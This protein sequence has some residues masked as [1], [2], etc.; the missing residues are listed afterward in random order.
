VKVPRAL[1]EKWE[2]RLRAEGLGVLHD[3]VIRGRVVV[4]TLVIS[5]Y[6]QLQYL[7]DPARLAQALD[8][9]ADGDA[10]RFDDKGHRMLAATQGCRP[11][12]VGDLRRW[13]K[14]RARILAK[15]CWSLAEGESVAEC[16]RRH[17]CSEDLAY[18]YLRPLFAALSDRSAQV[19]DD[20]ANRDSGD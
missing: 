19:D 10:S 16:A 13:P 7:P 18:V 6:P 11:D 17:G 1:A 14:R 20:D 5:H 8:A 4:R 12:R 2:R 15:I 9:W 3:Q